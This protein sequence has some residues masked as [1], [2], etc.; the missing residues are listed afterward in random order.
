METSGEAQP[1]EV[2]VRRLG[3]EGAELAVFEFQGRLRDLMLSSFRQGYLTTGSYLP[4][5]KAVSTQGAM[6]IAVAGTSLGATALSASLASTLYV[7]TADPSTLMKIGQGLGSAV[8]GTGGIVGQAPFLPVASS[9]PVAAPILA[10]QVLTTA[11]MMQQFEQVD[12]KLDT[13]KNTLDR[14][15]ARIEATHTGELLASSYTVDDVYSQYSLEGSFSQDMLVRLALAERDVRALAARFRQLVE[16][17]TTTNGAEL[18]E[19]QQ[20]NYDAHSAML[21]SF[22]ALRVAYLR[23]CVDMQE[24]PKS[25]EA[26]MQRLKGVIDDGIV[27]WQQLQGRSRIMKKEIRELEKK[28]QD[29]SWA[30]RN[31]PAGEAATLE[32]ELAKRKEAYTATMESEREIMSEFHSLIESAQATA[33]ALDEIGSTSDG[34]SPTLV[35]W[36]DETGEH[37]FVT[38]QKLLSS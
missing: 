2:A 37:S 14:A 23:V 10:I 12:R 21:A 7:A 8:M 26:S 28:L 25:V 29:M 1:Q 6:S 3:K 27:F 38:E 15:I 32:K 31:L 34:R 30:S 35:F 4:D 36:K 33:K 16:A 18:S 22:V 17:Q 24:N 11:M 5:A 13:I 19:V 20:A 9:L